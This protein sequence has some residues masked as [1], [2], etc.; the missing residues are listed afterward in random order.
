MATAF[1]GF[2]RR[3]KVRTV[4][5][6]NGRELSREQ[7]QAVVLDASRAFDAKRLQARMARV[8]KRHAQTPE[9][10]SIEKA[11]LAV[12]ER[13]VKAYW[14]LARL[15]NDKGIGFAKRNGVDYSEERE[16]RFANAVAAGGKWEQ[17]AP[18]PPVPSGREIDAMQ[19]PFDWLRWLEESDA[20]V[21]AAGAMWKRG[22]SGRNVNWIR[23]RASRPE[24]EGFTTDMLKVK[25]RHALREIVAEL[26]ARR[27]FSCR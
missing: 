9:R 16:D 20:R 15:P 24:L 25:Y 27:I 4:V 21:L 6:H 26:T 14:V 23:V 1:G 22:D 19:E 17:I 8:E 2:V 13:L 7:G 5:V 11:M 10:L 3:Q 12:E 18:R